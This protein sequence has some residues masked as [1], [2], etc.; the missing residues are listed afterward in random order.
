VHPADWIDAL[1]ACRYHAIVL[2]NEGATPGEVRKNVGAARRAMREPE[3][4]LPALQ[5]LRDAMSRRD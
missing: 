1:F 4:L 5:A 2:I 3:T